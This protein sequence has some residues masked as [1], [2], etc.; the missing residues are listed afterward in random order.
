MLQHTFY[1]QVEMI[2]GWIPILMHTRMDEEAKEFNRNTTLHIFLSSSMGL[3][4]S[5]LFFNIF[6]SLRHIVIY[7]Y[8]HD[9]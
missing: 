9:V 4:S 8:Y 1:L 6:L 5:I 2:N 7:I 3:Y